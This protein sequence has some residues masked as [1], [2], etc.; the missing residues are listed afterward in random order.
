MFCGRL[1]ARFER[2]VPL[3]DTRKK[4]TATKSKTAASNSKRTSSSGSSRSSTASKSAQSSKKTTPAITPQPKP[5]RRE[6]GAVV[7]LMLAF[8]CRLW[9]L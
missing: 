2:V 4:T 7:C 5:F 3:A 6:V 1:S 9:L 8:F